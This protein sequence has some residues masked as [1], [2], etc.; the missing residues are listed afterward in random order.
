MNNILE[1]TARQS[2]AKAWFETLRDE[3]CGAFEALEDEAP[4]TLY[5][6]EP[7]RFVRTPWQRTDHTRRR[8]TGS[9]FSGSCSISS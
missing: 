7:A 9:R 3:I 2:R 5:R 6:G 8:E 4:A 1:I